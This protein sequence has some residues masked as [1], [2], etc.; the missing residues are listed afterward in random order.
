VT[1]ISIQSVTPASRD[2][3]LSAALACKHAT[4][5][6]T[7][8]WYE[9]IA[10]KQKH[11]TAE[12]TFSDGASAVI[13]M[14]RIKRLCGLLTD[15]FSSPGGTYGGWVSAST[16]TP[17]HVKHLVRE[18]ISKSDLTFRV[19]PFDPNLRF[20]DCIDG[21]NGNASG[22]NRKED[23]THALDLTQGI[24][25]LRGGIS[26]SGKYAINLSARSGVTVKRA[27]TL[28]EWER[29]YGLYIDSLKRWRAGKLK[30]RT[31]YPFSLFRRIYKNRTGNEILWLAVKEGEPIAGV[32]VFYWNKHA[33]SW[34][35]SSS[36]E[37][38]SVK[39]NNLLYW[40]IIKDA[41]GRG[42]ELF[43]FNP[44]GGYGGVESFKDSF[45]AKRLPTPTITIRSRL[46]Q[47]AGKL[48]GA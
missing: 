19:N 9:L 28:D 47:M 22:I 41:A 18:L 45:G 3:W 34:H 24:I 30:T 5:F 37:H 46:R 8:Y 26:K 16:L 2:S 10:P 21:I 4:Y 29:Y 23:F 17:E 14:A 44:S 43:D 35:G 12:V 11:V 42:Y 33:V 13:P 15:V 40:E 38:F 25:R 48:R 27:E 31:V 39:P 32:L 6:H 20:I 36:S 1:D 7:P